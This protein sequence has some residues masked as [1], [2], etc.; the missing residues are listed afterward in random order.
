[1]KVTSFEIFIILKKKTGYLPGQHV[2]L[3]Q[4]L[5][6]ETIAP[7]SWYCYDATIAGHYYAVILEGL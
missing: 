5:A 6:I 2:E 7:Q 3:T 1:M 4:K